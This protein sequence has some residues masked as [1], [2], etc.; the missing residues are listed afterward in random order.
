MNQEE[1]EKIQY[2][3]KLCSELRWSGIKNKKAINKIRESLHYLKVA[4]YLCY[5]D[6]DLEEEM[7]FD[8]GYSIGQKIICIE[9]DSQD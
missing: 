4:E 1:I 6:Q 3:S 9:D 5:C 2:V 7:K 8:T